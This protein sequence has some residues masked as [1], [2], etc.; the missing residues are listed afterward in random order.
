MATKTGRQLLR[1]AWDSLRKDKE[2]IAVQA[3]AFCLVGGLGA[4]FVGLLIALTSRYDESPLPWPVIA[5]LVLVT[6]VA[7][8]VG[9]AA[10]SVIAA[11]ALHRLDGGTPTVASAC[12]Q[13]LR[14]WRAIVGWSLV[15]FTVGWLI[16]A[17]SQRLGSVAA[18]TRLVG[19]VAWAVATFF[20]VPVLVAEGIG[21]IR[22]V[23]RSKDLIASTWGNTVKAQIGA[24]V[25]GAL[26]F[27]PCLALMLGGAV[28]ASQG[29]GQATYVGGAMAAVGLAGVLAAALVFSALQVYLRVL[30]YRHATGMPVPGVPAAL[31][32]AAFTGS[33]GHLRHNSA[34]G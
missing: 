19:E 14:H 13:A 26:V 17:L 31:L 5:S 27:V 21:P 2:A 28:V 3:V 20:V 15:T 33:A 4:V 32:D 30:L 8:C 34:G 18:L 29:G 12:K 11:M 1:T 16:R 9:T 23:R 25:G 10:Q 6:L 22:A 24:F 7:M